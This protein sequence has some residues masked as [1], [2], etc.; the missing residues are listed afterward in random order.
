MARKPST[1]NKADSAAKRAPVDWE[2]IEREFLASQLSCS[3]IARRFSVSEAAIRKH[4][5]KNGWQRPLADKVRKAVRE[6]LV[7]D[8]SS[9]P[10]ANPADR[11]IEK[12][13]T[14]R[15]FELVTLHRK[16]V[17]Q[18]HGLKRTLADRLSQYLNGEIPDGPFI[19]EKETPAD[20]LEKLSRV[21]TRLIPLERQAYALDDNKPESG[22]DKLMAEINGT[23]W[24]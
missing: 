6:A 7:R 22:I 24:I 5:K 13:A 4:A 20:V 8:G 17:Q 21:T 3:E 15:G 23:G 19:G 11:E 18:L 16:D 12:A 1:A 14:L 10:R 9:H 2:G